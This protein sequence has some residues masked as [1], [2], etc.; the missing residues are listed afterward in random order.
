M[1]TAVQAVLNSWSFDPTITFGLIA[2]AILYWRGWSFLNRAAPKRFPT[3]RLW[4]FLSGLAALWAALFSPL[5]AF[6]GFLLSAHMV[7][8]LLLMLVAPPLVL[9]GA[10]MLPLLRGLPRKF[11]RDGVGP[12]LVW[13]ALRRVGS[14]IT[15]PLTCWIVAAVTLFIWHLPAAFDLTLRSR[16]WHK[17]EHACFF[18]ASLLFWWPVIL[19]FPARARWPRWSLPL[20]LLA[21]DLLNTAL[22]AI[23]TF[24]DHAL[25]ARYLEVPRLFG[26]TA[27]TDQSCAGVIMWVPGSLVYLVPAAVIAFQQ[28]SPSGLLTHLP[29]I[30]RNDPLAAPRPRAVSTALA[31]SFD[32]LSVPVI[33]P[34]LRKLSFRRALQAV[35]LLVVVATLVDGIFGPQ[36]GSANLAGVLP[37]TYWRILVVIGLLAAG[38]LFCMACPFMLVRELGKRLGFPQ[39]SWPK[40]LRSKWLAV[41][42]LILFFWA[43]EVFRLWDRPIWTAWLILNYFLI[44]FAVDAIFHGASFCKYVCPIGQFQFIGSLVSPL[45]VKV[46]LPHV[47]MSCKTHDCLVGNSRHRGCETNLYLPRKTGNLDCTFCLDCVRACPHDNIGV[48]LRTPVASIVQDTDRSSIGRFSRRPDVAALALVFVFAAFASAAFMTAPVEALCSLAVSR[49]DLTSPQPVMTVLSLVAFVLVPLAVG[50]M[51]ARASRMALRRETTIRELFCRFSVALIPLGVAMWMAHFIFHAAIGWDSVWPALQRAAGDVGLRLSAGS[52]RET[53]V[54]LLSGRAIQVWQ[55]LA[56]DAGFLG[57]LYLAWRV[58][59]TY[60]VSRGT[61]LRAFASW[62]LVA[63]LLYAGGIWIIL[64]P[65][66]MRGIPSTAFAVSS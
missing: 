46:R 8:H 42:L 44:A 45:E 1:T 16:P 55:T 2:A 38:N 39:R 3:W 35:L 23:L 33:G 62:A 11:A 54:A 57:A 66:E 64:Q 52:I 37:W 26:T 36:V 10:P 63:T 49:L 58:A 41:L 24:S 22:S 56:L 29:S 27:L 59:L 31:S 43:Y 40:A 60:G 17:A 21:A 18:A 32:L 20:Y 25:Y 19:P 15:H 61:A 4:C 28:L 30:P 51:A 48:M 14:F 7:Q 6:S 5:D 53:P 34:L 65:M 9:L 12:F 50:L 47:C 13:P